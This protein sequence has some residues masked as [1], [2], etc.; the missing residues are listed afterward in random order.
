MNIELKNLHPLEI[1]VLLHVEQGEE[2]KNDVLKERLQFNTGQCNQAFSWLSTKQLIEDIQHIEKR[3]YEIT[4]LGKTYQQ[5]G[6]PEERILAFVNGNGPASIPELSSALGLENKDA[7]SAFGN[8]SKEKVLTMNAEKQ[9][10]PLQD[11]PS[12]RMSIVRGLLDRAVQ[13][14]DSLAEEDLSAEEKKAIAAISKKRGAGGT[15]FKVVE[16]EEVIYSLTAEGQKVKEQLI[17][18]GI[19]G[20][21][22]GTLSSEML[23]S[24]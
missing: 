7:G 9:V 12:D 13:T 3:S 20:E 24:G 1:K 15:E 11:T 17:A 6:T 8:L 22:A 23:A 21:E 18:E 19:T 14:G 4:D 16:G 5:D 2:I 10:S